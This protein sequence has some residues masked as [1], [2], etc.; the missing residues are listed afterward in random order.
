MRI[1]DFYEQRN[2][3]YAVEAIDFIEKAVELPL[4]FPSAGRKVRRMSNVREIVAG[5]FL[6]RYE[7]TDDTVTILRVWHGREKR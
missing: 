2:P 7:A 3:R 4:L 1:F 6:L 5:D